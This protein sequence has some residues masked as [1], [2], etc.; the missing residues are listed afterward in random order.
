MNGQILKSLEELES[1]RGGGRCCQRQI[2]S[3]VLPFG[4]NRV[5]NML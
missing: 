2:E 5:F 1:V 3:T 4:A